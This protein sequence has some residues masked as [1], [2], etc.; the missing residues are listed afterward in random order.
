MNTNDAWYWVLGRTTGGYGYDKALAN[1]AKR[2]FTDVPGAQGSVASISSMQCVWCDESAAVYDQGA[3]FKLMDTFSDAYAQVMPRPADYMAVDAA[4]A[5]VPAELGVYTDASVQALKDAQATV[6]RN[7]RA[8]EQA[9][10][11]AM[12]AAIKDAVANLKVK[13]A[14]YAAVDAALAKVPADLTRYEASGVAALERAR[15]AV[16]RDLDITHQTELDKMAAAIK[17]AVASLKPRPQHRQGFETE[18]LRKRSEDTSCTREC[19]LP[20]T[21]DSARVAVAFAAV[22]GALVIGAASFL[23]RVHRRN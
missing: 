23:R 1:P 9:K 6:V 12:A 15:A 8:S 13:P 7:L 14:D 19:M 21:G 5:T 4:L 2:A 17:D 20:R 16:V 22:A 10:V 18:D 11:D 3:T